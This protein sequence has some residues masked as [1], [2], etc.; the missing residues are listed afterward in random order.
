MSELQITLTLPGELAVEAAQSESPERWVLEL[1]LCQLYAEGKITTGQAARLL[2]VSRVDF[3]AVLDRRGVPFFD[4][5]AEELA[6]D[7]TNARR[8]AESASHARRQ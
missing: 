7:A 4:L 5:S 3:M 2:G 1:I 6:A 8:A